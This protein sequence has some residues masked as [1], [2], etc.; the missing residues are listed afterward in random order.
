MERYAKLLVSEI[1][2]IETKTFT[3]E[4]FDCNVKFSFDLVP[5]D[6]KWAAAFSGELLNSA[7]YFSPFG[8]VNADDKFQVKGSLGTAG[9]CTWNPW[10][11]QDRLETASKVD[12]KEKELEKSSYAKSTKRNKI[13]NFIRNENSRQEFQPMLG[14][15]VDNMY[16][17]PLHNGNNAWQ[18]LHELMLQHAVAK[19]HILKSCCTLAGLKKCPF[20]SHLSTLK[21]FCQ[22][23]NGS[24][25]YRFTGKETKKMCHHFMSLVT[26]ISSENDTPE[27]ELHVC[28]FAFVR[29]QLRNATSKFSRT[30][31]DDD[32][33]QDLKF[34][35]VK[36]FLALLYLCFCLFYEVHAISL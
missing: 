30:I 25:S 14:K 23:R 19:S 29:L 6:M 15:L 10:L 17:E 33:L 1:S 7:F 13:L 3:I 12:S 9:S 22:G 5:C 28:T 4:E 26:A 35:L 16:A 21:W 11:F 18:Q 31:I 27:N 24:L 34:F 32:V 2:Q 8:N 36:L 20:L